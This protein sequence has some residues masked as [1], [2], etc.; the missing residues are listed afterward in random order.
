M[1]PCIF[2][3]AR[4]LF[5]ADGF[6]VQHSGLTEILKATYN[7]ITAQV[8]ARL[9][10]RPR[11]RVEQT[12]RTERYESCT[13]TGGKQTALVL[14]CTQVA[15]QTKRLRVHNK[16]RRFYFILFF[17]AEMCSLDARGRAL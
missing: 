3:G 16:R 9:S 7:E 12:C 14:L 17:N 13:D 10:L 1:C 6:A 8:N 5:N 2:Y 4:L 11:T 15:E